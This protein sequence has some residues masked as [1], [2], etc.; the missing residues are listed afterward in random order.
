MDAS[1]KGGS[2]KTLPLPLGKPLGADESRG[3]LTAVLAAMLE[4]ALDPNT[5]RAAAY[6]LQVDRKLAETAD[7]EHRIAALEE[8][9]HTKGR[10]NGHAE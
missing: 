4:G 2:R 8:I 6:I 5:A 10:S 9:V 1:R 7:L 3:L